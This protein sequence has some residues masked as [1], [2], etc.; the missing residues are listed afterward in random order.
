[1]QHLRKMYGKSFM[2]EVVNEILSNST[3]TIIAERGEKAAMQPDVTMTEDEK[4]AEQHPGRRRRFRV[5]ARL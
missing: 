4:E 1:M 5:Q 3:R 2:A